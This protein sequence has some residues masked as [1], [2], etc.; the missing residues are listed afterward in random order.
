MNCNQCNHPLA[1]TDRS[2]PSCGAPVPFVNVPVK[3]SVDRSLAS[4]ILGILASLL[5]IFG[6]LC[7]TMCN[8]LVSSGVAPFLMIFGGSVLGLCGA[9]LCL[10]KARIGAI[11]QLGSCLLIGI[12]V[13]AISGGEFLTLF[14]MIL[15]LVS[16]IVG[17]VES[18]L[19]SKNK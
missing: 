5:G 14:S 16:G 1:Q 11:I 6:G 19:K 2:C 18:I 17:L 7:V 9:C 10:Y 12:C 4:F 3:K 15:F 13:F 8:S